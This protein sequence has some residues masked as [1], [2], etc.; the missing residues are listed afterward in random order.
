MNELSALGDVSQTNKTI[1]STAMPLSSI[2]NQKS[3][4][5]RLRKHNKDEDGGYYLLN[6][7]NNSP[8]PRK[9]FEKLSSK[10]GVDI[11]E[12]YKSKYA[13]KLLKSE[14][15]NDNLKQSEI[16]I[17]ENIDKVIATSKKKVL[18]RN[19]NIDLDEEI[20]NE[21]EC[22]LTGSLKSSQESNKEGLII[23]DDKKEDIN[24]DK[25]N[26]EEG[27]ESKVD[28]NE[29]IILF[30]AEATKEKISNMEMNMKIM[31]KKKIVFV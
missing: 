4:S 3:F 6:H 15:I 5:I 26:A 23:I 27:E 16:N 29:K 14:E 12:I 18:Q 10:T 17:D 28:C 19:E 22:F 11:L 13:N 21:E 20:R 8:A 1:D 31:K 2:S 25:L 7:N 30:D 24:D 9:K